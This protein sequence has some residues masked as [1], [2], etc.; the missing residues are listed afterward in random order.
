MIFNS[1]TKLILLY[2]LFVLVEAIGI[3]LSWQIFQQQPA[4]VYK[5]HPL[6]L[7][8][9]VGILITLIAAGILGWVSLILKRVDAPATPARRP[10]RIWIGL[11]AAGGYLA[12]AVAFIHATPLRVFLASWLTPIWLIGWVVIVRAV[13]TLDIR[14]LIRRLSISD[15][16]M[17]VIAFLL[18]KAQQEFKLAA[19]L[20][21]NWRNWHYIFLAFN[22]ILMAAVWIVKENLSSYNTIYPRWAEI[23]KRFRSVLVMIAL[24]P[25]ILIAWYLFWLD[26]ELGEVSGAFLRLEWMILAALLLSLAVDNSSS[27]W[28]SSPAFLF[29]FTGVGFAVMAGAYLSRVTD[30]P[31]RPAL[32]EDRQS[33]L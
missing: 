29:S 4:G 32:L 20:E 3:P 2:L 9:G 1:K 8:A 14:S 33:V 15:W 13:V 18:I 7:W 24:I 30:H 16:V 6:I 23:R 10:S 19:P 28:I 21:V 31:F 27:K 11:A 22:T 25:T 12:L 17:V 26:S 5:V